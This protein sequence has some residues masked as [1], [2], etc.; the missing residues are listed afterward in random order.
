METDLQFRAFCVLRHLGA[1][2][3]WPFSQLSSV[4]W[5]TRSASSLHWKSPQ[6]FAGLPE[7][8]LEEHTLPQAL[9]PQG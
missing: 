1:V 4:G 2:E 7:E 9:K 3:L 5:G 6:C 8:E